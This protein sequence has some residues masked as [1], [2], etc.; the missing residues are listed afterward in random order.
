[1]RTVNV[2]PTY[3]TLAGIV[4]RDIEFSDLTTKKLAVALLEEMADKL[5]NL[6]ELSKEENHIKLADGKVE[7]LSH[8]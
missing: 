2:A 8:V 1:M 4:I 6:N 5:D 7:V 3:A